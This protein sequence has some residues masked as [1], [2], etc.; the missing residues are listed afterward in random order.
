MLK[1]KWNGT[2]YHKILLTLRNNNKVEFFNFT[3]QPGENNI[4]EDMWEK[5]KNKCLPY[6]Q[7]GKLEIISEEKLEEIKKKVKIKKVD[8]INTDEKGE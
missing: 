8:K 2:K 3:L 6:T 7:N 4:T 1:L 5:I